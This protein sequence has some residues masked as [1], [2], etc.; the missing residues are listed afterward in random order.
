MRR[1][2]FISEVS[3]AKGIPYEKIKCCNCVH[4][5]GN[6]GKKL[7]DNGYRSYCRVFREIMPADGVSFSFQLIEGK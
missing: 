5:G 2:D 7:Y 3:K 6:R 1:E 4:W